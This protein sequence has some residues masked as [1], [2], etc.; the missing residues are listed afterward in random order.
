MWEWKNR[1][2][3][4]KLWRRCLLL[5]PNAAWNTWTH[6]P[7][8]HGDHIFEV[9]MG[10]VHEVLPCI[11]AWGAP[12]KTCGS[13]LKLERLLHRWTG[14]WTPSGQPQPKRPLGARPFS[15]VFFFVSWVMIWYKVEGLRR[16]HTYAEPEHFK[17]VPG[18]SGHQMQ[19]WSLS[20]IWTWI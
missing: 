13:F 20:Q 17:T 10:E 9:A 16:L 19:T 2:T 8:L 14:V 12:K 15:T 4:V 3:V 18:P 1:T 7:L 11:K 5:W 6:H